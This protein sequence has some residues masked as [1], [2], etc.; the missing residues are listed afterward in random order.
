M[1]HPLFSWACAGP[2]PRTSDDIQDP[3]TTFIRG[4]KKCSCTIQCI[5]PGCPSRK[6]KLLSTPLLTGTAWGG[7]QGRQ[8]SAAPH[9]TL[10]PM[11][12]GLESSACSTKS[13]N[14]GSPCCTSKLEGMRL[15]F[16]MSLTISEARGPSRT[17]PHC[18]TTSNRDETV[19]LPCW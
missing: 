6:L 7:A 9:Q 4:A 10:F 17:S 3:F 8:T 12:G 19:W 11:Q 13:L 14:R 16:F 5:A 15:Y 2:H 1:Q 18:V